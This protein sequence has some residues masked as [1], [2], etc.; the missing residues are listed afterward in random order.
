MQTRSVLFAGRRNAARS[1]IAEACFNAAEIP[2]WR[3]F[4]AGWA[5]ADKVDQ[6]AIRVLRENR[7]PVEGLQPKSI[8]LFALAGAPQIDLCIHLDM[9][10]PEFELAGNHRKLCWHV[11]DPK[12]DPSPKAYAK[13]LD[14]V[15]H[16]IAGLIVSGDITPRF[17][18]LA[19]PDVSTSRAA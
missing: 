1:V 15:G 8:E 9:N 5:T 18:E 3:A 10:A 11:P 7:L 4:S 12:D 2:G 13:V 6:S 17:P 16:A 14:L 19:L